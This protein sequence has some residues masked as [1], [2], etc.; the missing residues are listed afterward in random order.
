MPD[1]SEEEHWCC[2]DSGGLYT[3]A[4]EEEGGVKHGGKKGKHASIENQVAASTSLAGSEKLENEHPEQLK[5]E[6]APPLQVQ[7][8]DKKRKLQSMAEPSVLHEVQEHLLIRSDK[9]KTGYKGVR[10]SH[11]RYRAQCD[12]PPCDYNYL[13]R[14]DT[15]EDAAQSYLQH[16]QKKHPEELKQERAPRPVLLPVQEHLLI[17]SDRNST[18]YKGVSPTKGRYRATCDTSPCHHNHLGTFDTLEDAAQLYLQHYQ[19][20]HPEE[21]KK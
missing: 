13:G 21:F 1:P 16:Y 8:D 15:L 11:G 14:F 2:K 10:A 17:R 9:G 5:K 6:R 20:E 7:A 19:K 18:G 4:Q 3:C 12:T